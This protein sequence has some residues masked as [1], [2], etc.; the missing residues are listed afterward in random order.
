MRRFAS[1]IVL[2][3]A[4][5]LLPLTLAWPGARAVADEPPPAASTA[6]Q[7]S[8]APPSPTPPPTAPPATAPAAPLVAPAPT[9]PATTTAPAPLTPPSAQRTAAEEEDEE[10]ALPAELFDKKGRLKR[11]LRP[12]DGLR[13]PAEYREDTKAST[14]LWA[15]GVGLLGGGYGVSAI[16][17]GLGWSFSD[18]CLFESCSKDDEYLLGFIPLVGGFVASGYSEVS[19][20]IKAFLIVGGVAQNVGLGLLIAGLAVREPVWVLKDEYRNEATVDV[21]IGPGTIGLGGRF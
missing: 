18:F 14:G 16:A 5:A 20:G 7:P 17:A 2:C 8:A 21:V 13:L 4:A 1:P 19:D 15:T 11:K 10:D 9:S 3:A 12:V 6:A